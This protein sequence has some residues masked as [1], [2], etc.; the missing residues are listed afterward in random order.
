M[1]K[2]NVI[3][4]A[5]IVLVSA[6]LLFLWVYMGFY[7]VDNPLDLI[8]S[9]V[10]WVVLA[11]A[12]A[13]IVKSEKTRRA[14]IR[15]MYIGA[16]ALFNSEEGLVACSGPDQV[17]TTM[18]G[19]L[20]DLKYSFKREDAPEGETFVAAYLVKTDTYKDRGDVWTGSIVVPAVD[21]SSQDDERGFEDQE[22]LLAELVALAPLAASRTVAAAP[23]T[24]PYPAGA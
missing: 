7:R 20:D 15:R 22:E 10:W 14:R 5:L 3:I 2:S 19:I 17:I 1:K 8:L 4:T 13:V 16:D 21:D 23:R 24:M 6:F 9:I 18:G 11:L 12:I